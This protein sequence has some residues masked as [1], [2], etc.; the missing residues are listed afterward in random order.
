MPYQE[1]I[2]NFAGI[3]DYMR[4]F[5]VYGF[6]SRDEYTG[7]S[8][9]TYDDSRRRIESWLGEHICVQRTPD[10][11]TM[12]LSIDTRIPW[13]DPLFRAWK[14]ASFTDGDITLH[15]LLLDVLAEGPM[16]LQE[17]TD[18]IDMRLAGFAEPMLFDQS[19]VRK[20]L[21]EYTKLGLL[22]SEKQRQGKKL[23]WH[24]SPEPD[25][26]GWQDALDFFT[27]AAPCGVIGSFLTDRFPSE[28][29]TEHKPVF[30]F[31]HHYIAHTL[32]SAVLLTLFDAM[33]SQR[34]VTI[35]V[36]SRRSR[37]GIPVDMTIVPLRIFISAQSG[38]QYCMA[39]DRNQKRIH[40]FRLDYILDA[41]PGETA[42]DFMYLR[43]MLNRMQAHI[44]GVST[45]SE[46]GPGNAALE[47][48]TFTVAIGENE[49]YIYTR[50]VRENRCGTVER[51]DARTARFTAKVYDAGELVP[52]IRTFLCRI[53]SIHFS[54]PAADRRFREDIAEMDRIY[55]LEDC[56]AIS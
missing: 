31:K 14:S 17:I 36:L 32:D 6:K 53:T 11:K 1:L 56:C 19:T 22:I 7:K 8:G 27:E 24:L 46:D 21:R 2:K 4:E 28:R 42:A 3:R 48:V 13:Q 25:L 12:S 39:F 49:E 15:F 44:W 35:R 38:R 41:E 50:L 37:S 23:V 30:S 16:T 33:H 29:Q 47:E 51:L 55:G 26:T 20:K 10:G 54:N 18:A 9:R 52:W 40:S 43:D 34:E 45:A 5:A